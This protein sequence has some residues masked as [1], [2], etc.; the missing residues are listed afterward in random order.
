MSTAIV[1]SFEQ[2]SP[3]LPLTAKSK[4]GKARMQAMELLS[5]AEPATVV[6][7]RSSGLVLV[8]ADAETG[9]NAAQALK[10]SGLTPVL[11]VPAEVTEPT[12]K[13][14]TPGIDLIR[15]RVTQAAGHLGEFVITVAHPE[16]EANLAQWLRLGRPHFD[17]VLD[18]GETPLIER[19]VLPLGYYAPAGDAQRQ[20][21]LAD[22]PDL[23]GEFVKPKF[24]NYRADICAHSASNLTGCSRCLN[25]CPTE[26]IRSI[27][28]AIEVDPQLCQ[29]VGICASACPTG[30]I[31][32]AYP[33]V[34]DLLDNLRRCLHRYYDNGGTTPVLLLHDNERGLELL[35]EAA[36]E[37]PEYIIPV[38]L[39]EIG[40]AGLDVYLAGL[41]YGAHQLCLLV[42]TA[43]TTDRVID[44][45]RFQVEIATT[46]LAGMGYPQDRIQ[47]L[48]VENN[49]TL[50]DQLPD[51]EQNI[52]APVT[53]FA[54]FAE[55]RTTIRLAVDHFLEH[56]PKLKKSVK[57][58]P[59][60]PFGE[61][62]V[63][64][65]KCTLCLACVSVCPAA[66]LSDGDDLPKLLFTEANCVQCSLC[67]QACPEH[68][69]ILQPRFCYDIEHSGRARVLNEE[70]PFHC[71]RCGK[72]FATQSVMVRM[73]EKLK[74]HWM[75]QNPKQMERLKMCE[76]CRI[77]DMVREQ[78]DLV[79][80][81]KPTGSE[82]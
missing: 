69:I 70:A 62:K 67:A 36:A 74:G 26:A 42:P 72:P 19:D 45:L 76:D 68:A 29:G 81:D 43:T 37:L 28:D 32:Y 30:A 82:V 23:I 25:A 51:P 10:E 7:F 80:P 4:N 49:K 27:V 44:E 58:P 3:A 56:A 14:A 31:S 22:L 79:S 77:E 13:E 17:L 39:A 48:L 59:G 54:A 78:G 41:A 6:S 63:D 66:A 40:S 53:G 15:S 57:L 64:R 12:V 75:Y 5:Q 1:D 60:A 38:A 33:P 61:I 18:L 71:V 47:L 65:V 2:Q 11:L 55:K 20:Q 9:L 8:V 35:H 34:N 21:A 16:G 46:L 50:V 24:F 73:Q 52:L